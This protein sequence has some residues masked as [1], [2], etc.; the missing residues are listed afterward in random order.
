MTPAGHFVPFASIERGGVD[1]SFHFGV[2]VLADGTGKLHASWG[3][4]DFVTF[5]RSALKPFQ[6]V[7]LVENGA[8]D[9]FGLASEQLAL[10]CAS[11]TGESFHV[12]RVEHWLGQL[13]CDAS[14]LACGPAYPGNAEALRDYL[15]AGR[16]PSPLLY[17]CSGK[18]CGFLT[19]ARHLGLPI[20]AYDAPDHPLQGRYR[21]VFSRFLGHDADALAWSRDDCTLPAPALA[22]RDMA[23]AA[24]RFTEEAQRR[25]SA[26]ARI[27]S[28]MAAH[29]L[30]LAGTGALPQILGEVLPG[31][32]VV[33]TGAEGYLLVF[34]PTERLGLALKVADG[35]S[36]ARDV[37]LA[38]MLHQLGM[39]DA[40][41]A[42]R[43]TE[44]VAPPLLDSR[45]RPV[46]SIRPMLPQPSR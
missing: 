13:G 7:D 22:M 18:H 2:G 30:L 35:A 36:R 10:A 45:R 23:A 19:S 27:L 42:A 3:D 37:A 16:E 32:F 28:A 25:D 9:A 12:E 4:P 43:L 26:P 6:A 1:E 17:N 34:F 46:G 14:C 11:H 5:P 38:A 33:K 39:I 8:F 15:R 44:R 21:T 20:A 40:A 24:A 31:R 41:E 29:P